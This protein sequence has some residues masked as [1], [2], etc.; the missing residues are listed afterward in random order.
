MR[1]IIEDLVLGVT[2]TMFLAAVSTPCLSQQG[3]AHGPLAIPI[4][5]VM[6]GGETSEKSLKVDSS[7]NLSLCVTQ[8]T[9]TVN[10]W[11]R[12]ELRVFVQ[13]GSK[14]GFKV[15]QKSEKTG[16][17]VWV[18]VLGLEAKNKYVGECIRGGEIEID[19]PA[20]AVVN[21]KGEDVN[22]TVDGIRKANVQVSGGSIW[23]RNIAQGVMARTF[24]GGITVEE[25]KGPMEL[26]TSNGNIVVFEAGPSEI[27]DAFAARTEG[28]MVS[29][30]K[31]GHRQLEVSSITGSVAYNGAIL[32]GGSYSLSTTTGSIR[33][34]IPQSSAC[35]VSATYGYGRF[36]SDLPLKIATENI[37]PGPV[38]TIVGTLGS[39]GD[40]TLKLTSNNGSIVIRKQ[41]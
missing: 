31:V 35:T 21:V 20:N 17:P 28:G 26:K 39:G 30:Q 4:A 29:L 3:P 15:A 16:D 33:L 22:T 25:S 1:K 12:N 40:A 19:V 24:Q 10:S 8:G 32:S 7:V 37:T 11:K 13:D 34:V 36:D 41:P 18:M 5:P 9:V 2:A 23:L 38:K 27:G 14:F 6:I